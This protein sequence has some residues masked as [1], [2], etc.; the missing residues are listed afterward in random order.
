MRKGLLLSLFILIL[1]H[2]FGQGISLLWRGGDGQW[3]NANNWIQI[4]TPVGQTPIQ[5]V[6][7]EFDHVRISS[8]MSGLTRVGIGFPDSDSLFI[9]E[10][11]PTGIR[12][13]SMHVSNT[14]LLLDNNTVRSQYDFKIV[15]HTS[16]GGKVLI[17][18]G[19]Y[20]PHGHFIL[21]GGNPAIKDLEILN[22]SFGI[23]RPRIDDSNI[24]IRPNGKARL[25]NS[26]IRGIYIGSVANGGELI[27][28]NCNF[29]VNNY[30]LGENSVGS[31]IN[32]TIAND[33]N[34]GTMNFHIGKNSVFNSANGNITSF[35]TLNF[36][37]SGATLRGNVTLL[38]ESNG[39]GPGSGGGLFKF[40]QA[41]PSNPLP[42]IIDGNL[43]FSQGSV[44]IRG[45]VKISGD[46]INYGAEP[47]FYPDTA[48]VFVN[49]QDIFKIG[50]INNF[51]DNVTINNCVDDICHF[52]F[53][54]F[55]NTNSRVK[56]D[57]GF[58]LDTMIVNKTGCGKVTIDN[59]LYV[60]SQLR[61]LSGQ[62]VLN[63]NNGI[64][65][66]MVCAGNVLVSPGAGIFLRRNAAGVPANIAI[67]GTLI[68]NNP[69]GDSTCSGVSNPYNGNILLYN[70]N[71]NIITVPVCVNSGRTL[72]SNVTGSTYR[73]EQN[74][75]SGFAVISNNINFSGVTS[76][77]LQLLNIPSAWSNYTFRCIVNGNIPSHT[78]RI[79][80]VS[81]L[82]ASVTLSGTSQ[83]IC[84]GGQT[85]I[86]ASAINAGE[87]PT[88]QWQVNG[89]NAGGN[90]PQ[91][92]SLNLV[93]NDQIKVV[94]QS[95]LS[96]ATPQLS[97]SNIVIV[98]TPAVI[99]SVSIVSSATTVC[100]GSPVTF[101]AVP[102][103]GG[104][105]PTYQWI[106]NGQFSGT[107]PTQTIP[108]ITSTTSVKVVMLSSNPCANPVSVSSNPITVT[109]S[110]GNQIPLVSITSSATAICNNQN[111]TFTATPVNGGTQPN[112]QW[113]VNGSNGG[114][115]SPTFS[116]S[117]LSN[118]SVVKVIMTSSSSCTVPATATSNSITLT[119]GST[120][121]PSISIASSAMSICSN[122]AVTF[123]ASPVNGGLAPIYQWKKNGINV[124]T[125]N[126]QFVS[127]DLV[128]GDVITATI[129][130][131]AACASAIPFS[132][133]A[134]TINVTNSVIPGI[135]INGSQLVNAGDISTINSTTSNAGSNP[136]YQWQ[137]S[138]T[139]HTWQN[140]TGANNPLLNYAAS[141]TGDKLR[142]LLTSNANCANPLVAV[143]NMLNF[144]VSQPVGAGRVTVYPNPANSFVMVDS[145]SL[146]DAWSSVTILSLQGK[147]YFTTNI[148]GRNQVKIPIQNL[149]SG[150]YIIRLNRSIGGPVHKNFI[151]L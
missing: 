61:V 90:S 76:R 129:V 79:N 134:I 106:V 78:F 15:V 103:N 126:A 8:S 73:W 94:V 24:F 38:L 7:T 34:Y 77:V 48:H 17:D 123:T 114:T 9:G 21:N 39:G 12:C 91:F 136:T 132:S 55:G 64:A 3:N 84:A 26:D 41:D 85:I 37:T 112:Y 46:L 143:S 63:P 118:N 98:N 23:F 13:R 89:V 22:S 116:S 127:A 35:I 68:N 6:P 10:N 47:L 2:A 65:Y 30:I 57:I 19:A 113:Q 107:A 96:C 83:N 29:L 14:E 74:T 16:N 69:T 102:T 150:M 149:L 151:K 122:T 80:V 92:S 133:N 87:T 60:A 144:T 40:G 66:K 50:G 43:T 51:L 36:Y 109:V 27:T 121:V 128:S 53:E 59:S 108:S 115:N 137:D 54:F 45:D 93:L 99:P 32:S 146:V 100:A 97:T 125:N 11:R 86:T 119:T 49:G 135:T 62:L 58:P 124:G 101:T 141:S 75:G 110:S 111:I 31:L 44:A 148:S 72:T 105:A 5:R 42:N 4:N 88:F 117:T 120:T 95:S 18:S 20:V 70:P 145:L 67:G 140:I 71:I 25:L 142:V 131:N 82:P 1:S 147:I 130:S 104:L 81:S 56:W 139:A 33:I 52:K 28:E 138:T